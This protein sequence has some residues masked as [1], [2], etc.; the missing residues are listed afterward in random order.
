MIILYL[1]P[2]LFGLEDNNP[3]GLK[4]AT[5]LKMTKLPFEMKHI[6]DT[7]EAPRGQLPYMEIDGEITSDSNAMIEKILK[8]YQLP[9]DTN[10]SEKEKALDFAIRCMLDEHLYWVIAY[11]RWQDEN[12]WPQFEEVLIGAF[13]NMKKGDLDGFRENNI[14]KYQMQ[15][16]GRYSPQEVYKKGIQDL[17]VI[18]TLLSDEGYFFGKNPHTIDACIYGFLAN[19]YYYEIETPLRS[20]IQKSGKLPSYLDRVRFL[21]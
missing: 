4:V 10:L 2:G 21:G 7:S 16:I 11:S 20:F 19:I 9:I 1:Y 5:F 3:F 15:G 8:T 6:I 12:Y 13:S 17:K 14:N 18:E